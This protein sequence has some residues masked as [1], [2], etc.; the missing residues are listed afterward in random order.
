M[1]HIDTTSLKLSSMA[2]FRDRC[3]EG[4]DGPGTADIELLPYLLVINAIPGVYTLQSCT[5]HLP[6]ERKYCADYPYGELW[7]SLPEVVDL[8]ES[9]CQATWVDPER[10][11]D[12][13]RVVSFKFGGHPAGSLDRDLRAITDYLVRLWARRELETST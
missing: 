4:G 13:K 3:L 9:P 6:H 1:N 12:D 8:S 5:G 2:Y 10:F 7:V 11:D